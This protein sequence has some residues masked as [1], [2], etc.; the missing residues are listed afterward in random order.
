MTHEQQTPPP[1]E[2]HGTAP[3][4]F[5]QSISQLVGLALAYGET[6]DMYYKVTWQH[7]DPQAVETLTPMTASATGARRQELFGQF[8]QAQFRLVERAGTD[9][10]AQHFIWTPVPP[11]QAGSERLQPDPT[12]LHEALQY[13]RLTPDNI[14]KTLNDKAEVPEDYVVLNARIVAEDFTVRPEVKTNVRRL[15]SQFVRG[16]LDQTGEHADLSL[17]DLL[18]SY[19]TVGVSLPSWA[20]QHLIA[21]LLASTHP[22]DPSQPERAVVTQ[23]AL[24]MLSRSLEQGVIDLTHENRRQLLEHT[25]LFEYPFATHMLLDHFGVPNANRWPH[26][27]FVIERAAF[28]V[29]YIQ[30]ILQ[31]VPR[32]VNERARTHHGDASFRK[33]SELLLLI[34]VNQLARAV[35]R[36]DENIVPIK[37][38]ADVA[39]TMRVVLERRPPFARQNLSEKDAAEMID[40]CVRAIEE[41]LQ[42]VIT[43]RP[44]KQLTTPDAEKIVRRMLREGD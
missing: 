4:S 42:P 39:Q 33:E 17:F 5:E 43:F 34:Y 8:H 24:D 21:Q 11:Y 30:G 27:I 7:D 35:A 12:A 28:T 38:L 41:I 3:T 20:Q 23:R 18:E 26:S 2:Q 15:I 37:S 16:E 44:K 36:P 40:A 14:I 13:R 1:Q 29:E 31:V 6:E 9:A 10:A 32:E 19:H 22:M 25:Q